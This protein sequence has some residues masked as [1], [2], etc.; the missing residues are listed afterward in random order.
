MDRDT[1]GTVLLKELLWTPGCLILS[2]A[3]CW[4]R[5]I[6]DNYDTTQNTVGNP[7][8]KTYDAGKIFLR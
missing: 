8:K 3:S 2:K 6:L 4:P 7:K 1:V 5:F